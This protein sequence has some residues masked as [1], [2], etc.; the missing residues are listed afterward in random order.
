MQYDS[1]AF[2]YFYTKKGHEF[3]AFEHDPPNSIAAIFLNGEE[4]VPL[5]IRENIPFWEAPFAVEESDFAH[6]LPEDLF[7]LLFR[8]EHRCLVPLLDLSQHGTEGICAVAAL[9]EEEPDAIRW[10]LCFAPDGREYGL[11]F[12]FE[13]CAYAAALKEL[14]SI[15]NFDSEDEKEEEENPCMPHQLALSSFP[16]PKEEFESRILPVFS[17]LICAANSYLVV[18][19]P[20]NPLGIHFVQTAVLNDDCWDVE[21]AREENGIYRLFSLYASKVETVI[22]CFRTVCHEGSLP[23]QKGWID[24]TGITIG[25]DEVLC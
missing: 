25:P 13:K 2:R 3:W 17:Q 9:I 18:D 5:L 4:L 8:A 7:P 6:L 22:E 21:Y 15:C 23:A 10:T 1:L 11:S 24:V 14:E 12:R 20:K 19:L 16:C